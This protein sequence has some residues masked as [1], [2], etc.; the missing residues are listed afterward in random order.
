MMDSRL[1]HDEFGREIYV[2]T[3]IDITE[4][5]QM[6]ATLKQS[7]RRLIAAQRIAKMGDFTWEVESGAVTWSEGLFELLHYDKLEKI[8]YAK[9]NARIHHPEDLARV[10]KWLNDC[11]ASGQS[12]LTP[13]EY[14]VIRKDGQIIHV[15]TVGVIERNAGKT[16]VFA[17]VHDITG[18][19]SR[20]E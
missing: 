17:T 8:D 3:S 19:K 2:G 1:A 13:N 18:Q 4:R 16:T 6:L 9:V 15:R 20:G 14:P 7:E 11:I 5:K 10:T 12:E